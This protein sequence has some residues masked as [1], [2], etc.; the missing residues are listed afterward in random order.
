MDDPLLRP[1]TALR[2]E[3]W[4]SARLTRAVK[5]G[6]LVRLRRG[7]YGA[8]APGTPES[9]HLRRALAEV[10]ERRYSVALSHV[11]AGVLWG[12]PVPR[13]HLGVVH[14][15][16]QP[17]ARSRRTPSLHVHVGPLAPWELEERDGASVTSL[18]RTAADV[19]RIVPYP[20]A[21]AASDWALNRGVTRA[22]LEA[23]G[24]TTRGRAGNQALLAASAFAQ[25]GSGS[26]AES[27]SRV[28]MARAGLPEPVLQFEVLD[29]DG[30]WVA[31]CDFGWPALGL[32]GEMDGKAK[33]GALLRP[34]QAPED[35]IMAEKE[36]EQAIRQA[37]YWIV[38]WGWKEAGDVRLL[39]DLVRGAIQ[40]S[41]RRGRGAGRPR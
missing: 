26:V 40:A 22:Q 4:T 23:F 21:V 19:A 38:R 12:V 3:G 11:S 10:S 37:G 29:A 35:A 28:T 14:L 41:D 30:E 1:W 6:E 5:T 20:W 33:Y 9:G 8:S 13:A 34:G 15:T 16:R 25:R 7:V 31:T 39:G 24:R 17:P 2:A 32:V 18:A 36:R 27:I